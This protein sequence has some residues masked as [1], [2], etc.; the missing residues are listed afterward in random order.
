[1]ADIEKAPSAPSSEHAP[2]RG[3][4]TDA[5]A[6]AALDFLR[7]DDEHGDV[8]L[9]TI[10]EKALLRKIDWTVMPVPPLF[11]LPSITTTNSG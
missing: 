9:S 3:I 5:N 4:T 1:M 11:P 6:D 8:S 7:R 10:D 2:E